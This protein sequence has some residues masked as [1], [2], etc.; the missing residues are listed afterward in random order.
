MTLRYG[1]ELNEWTTEW[2]ERAADEL[3]RGAPAAGA[4]KTNA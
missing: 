3:E 4:A 1:I 2:F